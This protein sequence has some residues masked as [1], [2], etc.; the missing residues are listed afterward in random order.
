MWGCIS[1]HQEYYIMAP[2]LNN[3]EEHPINY[4][5]YSIPVGIDINTNAF[6]CYRI[7]FVQTGEY[8]V[9]F[10]QGLGGGWYVGGTYRKVETNVQNF[11]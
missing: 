2:K 11:G 5:E 10:Y 7:P 9:K 1:F 4:E 8:L 3:N 6:L